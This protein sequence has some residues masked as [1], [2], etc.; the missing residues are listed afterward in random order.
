M[1]CNLMFLWR[2]FFCGGVALVALSCDEALP[3]YQPPA[4]V[5][6]VSV[7]QVEQ[8]N[9]RVAPP[10][11]QAVHVVIDGENV[12]DE[13]FL[14]SVRIEGNVRIWWK[15]KPSRY[16]TIPINQNNITNP[17][18]I[19]N[20]KMLLLPGQ[21]FSLDFYWNMRSVDSVY[22][23]YEMNFAFLIRRVCGIRLACA[24]PED[25]VVETSLVVYDR[26]GIL[27]APPK[28]FTFIAK[29]NIP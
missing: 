1:K 29:T 26:L 24:D 2:L 13:V 21:K 7:S 25:F 17:N 22:L 9:D 8:L 6:A 27:V 10:G 14:D 20:G 4:N 5:L 23:P 15:R 19:Q 28:E 12:H 18:L 16:I 3:V 11:R